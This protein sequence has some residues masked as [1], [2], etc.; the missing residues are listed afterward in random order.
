[1]KFL[2]LLIGDIRKMIS[3]KSKIRSPVIKNRKSAVLSLKTYLKISIPM[4]INQKNIS[5]LMPDWRA[6]PLFYYFLYKYD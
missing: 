2:S 5:Y 1:M 6:D 4:P 3:T